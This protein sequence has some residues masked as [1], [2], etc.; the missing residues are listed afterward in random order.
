M[1]TSEAK[2][3]RLESPEVDSR[4]AFKRFS[5]QRKSEAVMR[6]L[7]GEYLETLSRELGVA[8]HVLSSWR[9]RSL[10]AIR[11]ALKERPRDGSEEDVQRLKAKVGDLTME[12]ELLYERV[13]ALE[14]GHPFAGRRSRR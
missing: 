2:G 11:G 9:D 3:D 7:R 5:A 13:G 4:R 10:S 6:L 8:A 1:S 14:A 12:N